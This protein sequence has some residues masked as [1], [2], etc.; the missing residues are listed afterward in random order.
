MQMVSSRGSNTGRD[1]T[2][3]LENDTN[4]T[5]SGWEKLTQK[6]RSCSDPFFSCQTRYFH[7][8]FVSPFISISGQVRVKIRVNFGSILDQ[9]FVSISDQ[10]RVNFVLR[11]KFVSRVKFGSCCV[12][13]GKEKI[14][15]GSNTTRDTN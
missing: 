11:V 2:T 9:Y 4:F 6:N 7:V 5:G 1:T 8:N 3:R 15:H 12:R 13:V 10:F 14:R